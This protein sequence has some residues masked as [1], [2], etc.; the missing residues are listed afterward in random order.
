MSNAVMHSEVAPLTTRNLTV[1]AVSLAVFSSSVCV[2]IWKLSSVVASMLLEQRVTSPPETFTCLERTEG[3]RG[4]HHIRLGL[5]ERHQR[6]QCQF[7]FFS[8]KNCSFL[9]KYLK[10]IFLFPRKTFFSHASRIACAIESSP[11]HCFVR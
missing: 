4:F 8:R 10:N 2:G 3:S 11:D 5:G 7:F 1:F 6:R 9:E